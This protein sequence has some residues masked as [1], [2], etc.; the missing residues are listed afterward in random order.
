MKKLLWLLAVPLV[1]CQDINPTAGPPG[2]GLGA[3]CKDAKDCR[4]GLTCGASLRCEG[5]RDVPNDAVCTLGVECVSGYCA[6]N[7]SRGKCT[8]GGDGGVGTT[9]QGDGQCVAGLRC[10]F[11]G[12]TLFPKCLQPGTKDTGATCASST[13]CA[14]GLVCQGG[15]CLTLPLPPDA[16]KNGL[17]PVVPSLNAWTGAKCPEQKMAG[18]VTALWE[19]PREADPAE[20]KEDF[21]RLPYPNDAARDSTG[22][23]DY[24]RYPRDPAPPFGFDALKRYL[25][26]LATEPFG[27]YPNVVFRFDGTVKFGT[28]SAQGMSPQTRLVDLTQGTRFGQRHGLFYQLDSGRNRYVCH[29]WLAVRPFTADALRAG[30]YAVLLLKGVKDSADNDVKVAPDFAAMLSAS[31]PSDTR[32]TGAYA[33]YA[34]LRDYLQRES[35][36]AANVLTAA[37]F[38]VGEPARLLKK[39]A[40]SVQAAPVADAGVWVKCSAGLPSPCAQDGGAGACGSNPNLD[41]YQALISLPIFQQGTAPYLTPAQG[42]N[43][44]GTGATFAV[45]RQEAVCASLVTPKTTPPPGGWPLVVYA[46]GT[47]G[48]YRSHAGD[49]SGEGLANVTLP[50]GGSMG[51]AVLGFDQVGHGTRRGARQDV[52]P[53]DIVFNFANPA[54]A[55]GTMAQGAADL[56][57]IFRYF[58]GGGAAVPTDGGAVDGGSSDGGAVDGGRPDAGMTTDG[59]ADAGGPSD[60]GQPADAG[61]PTDAGMAPDAGAPGLFPGLPPLNTTH[62]LFWG[63]SQGATEGGL[64]LPFDRRVDGTL[65]S[66]ASASITDALLNKRAPVNIADSLWLALSES[67]PS[68]V[69]IFHPVL[70]LLSAWIDPVDPMNFSRDVVVVPADG[71][72]PA[73]GRHVFQVWGKDDLFTPRPVQNVFAM[74]AGLRLVGPKLPDEGDLTPESSAAGNVT[75]PRPLT[76]AVRQ[77]AP[78]GYDGHFVVVRDA[79]AKSDA[80]RFLARAARGEVPR[81]PEP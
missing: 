75:Q 62:L 23:V 34:P 19:V 73:Y 1:A 13:E 29:N 49:G 74:G 12:E 15:V 38:T 10:G 57:A 60:A 2:L 78:A 26:A 65:L 33:A 58:Q 77:Y 17:P 22:R 24:S 72:T 5:A 21:F 70:T 44:L 18:N 27:N 50:D 25:D 42:G 61:S 63:H 45:E 46:H 80:L 53:N 9:C 30:T 32:L 69:N 31:P 55:R 36:P 39:L 35:I 51:F 76:A 47:G 7:G 11:D 54:S 40:A 81:I 66:G 20:V 14:Q 59:G 67:Q 79:T 37:V 28:L 71:A 4:K 48:N 16:V 41:E 56:H 3:D 8:N 52:N 6:P 68:A 64:F 43:I